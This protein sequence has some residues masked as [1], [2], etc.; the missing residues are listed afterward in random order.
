MTV[1]VE[2]GRSSCARHRR[3]RRHDRLRRAGVRPRGRSDAPLRG[4]RH[5]G[6]QQRSTDCGAPMCA[7]SSSSRSRSTTSPRSCST[8]TTAARR[9]S[10]T[11]PTRSSPTTRTAGR[12][13]CGASSAPATAIVRYHAEDEGDEATWVAR[14]HA[15]AA[16]RR[17]RMMWKEMA[18]FYRTN[19]Q[20]RVVEEVAHALRRARTRWSAARASTTAARSRTRWRTCAPSSTRPTRSA[21]S[22]C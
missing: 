5:P 2:D 12:S 18:V 17:P 15:V 22:A 1:L 16:R 11:R 8:R 10:S 9:S 3:R 14:T 13:T 20:S 4:Q 19:A 21:S 6:A 7:T